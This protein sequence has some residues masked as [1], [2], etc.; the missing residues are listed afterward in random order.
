ME[1]VVKSRHCT[2]SEKFREIAQE[3]VARLDRFGYPIARTDVEL[4]R[5]TA[6]RQ[7]S[8]SERVEL[9]LSGKGPVVRAEA[10]AGDPLAALDMAISKVEARLRKLAG[11]RK[12]AHNHGNHPVPSVRHGAPAALPNLAPVA[13]AGPDLAPVA[14]A[15]LDA[16]ADPARAVDD[17]TG[18]GPFIVREKVHA[19]SPMTRDQALEQ[20]E[21]VG[22]DFF[23]Y[24][25]SETGM[26]SVV[27]R[28]RAYDYGVLH[29]AV[30]S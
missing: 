18:D 16:G 12:D 2:P 17:G 21:L 5:E 26:P 8:T 1:I 27:Y 4:S 19:A 28:R 24:C 15:V 11:R 25:C 22:H 20:M 14:T 7:S 13:G 10:H 9:T 30:Q 29:L 23:L 6:P 3:K